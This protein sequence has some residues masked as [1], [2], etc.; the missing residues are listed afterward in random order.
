MNL[1][2]FAR[3]ITWSR[4]V[5]HLL[6]FCFFLCMKIWH[7]PDLDSISESDSISDTEN[8]GEPTIT[9]GK[10][11]ILNKLQSLSFTRSRDSNDTRFNS[12]YSSLRKSSNSG[13]LSQNTSIKDITLNKSDDASQNNSGTKPRGNILAKQQ[14]FTA[15]SHINDQKFV[16]YECF[17]FDNSCME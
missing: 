11:I 17:H 7:I 12:R 2:T 10:N 3:L 13:T 6:V 16:N 5:I 9:S 15:K 8:E 1:K 4:Q 14:H